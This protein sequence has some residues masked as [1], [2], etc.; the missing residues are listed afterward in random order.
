VKID[1]SYVG[2][3]RFLCGMLG[4]GVAAMGAGVVVPLLQ[5]AGDLRETPP[6][7]FL[8]LEKADYELPPG[9]AK[10]VLYGQ[11]PVLLLRPAEGDGSLKVF[12][13]TCTHLNCTVTYQ[14]DKNRIYCACHNG[15]Y[16]TDGRVLS[17]PPPRP[18]REFYTKLAGGK[19]II[20]LEKANLEKAT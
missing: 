9:K 20:A 17:G 19:L 7:A 11:I 2:R 6:P 15:S 12:V 10:M 1:E 3:R 8:A 4:G 18:L 13:A 14:A 16:G 5:Y